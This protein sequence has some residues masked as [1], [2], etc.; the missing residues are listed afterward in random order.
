[1]GTTPFDQTPWLDDNGDGLSSPTDG[2]YAADRY[3]ASFFGGLMPDIQIVTLTVQSG[4]GTLTALVQRG[5]DEIDTVWAAVYAPSFHEPTITTLEL[6]V[7]LIAL[8]PDLDQE[9]RYSTSYNGFGESG[10]Y[11]VVL[12]ARDT[13]GNQALPKLVQTGEAKLYL[14]LMRKN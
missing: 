1:V 7:P 11:K 2:T 13:A 8:Q 4:V 14:P 5:D 6:G 9:G 3:V 10:I 12:Y